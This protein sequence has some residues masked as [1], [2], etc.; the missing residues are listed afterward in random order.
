MGHYRV[1]LVKNTLGG[2]YTPG[3]GMTKYKGI[4]AVSQMYFFVKPQISL[5]H[6]RRTLF[7]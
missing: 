1:K 5:A 2:D 3:P 4:R 7:I 6:R